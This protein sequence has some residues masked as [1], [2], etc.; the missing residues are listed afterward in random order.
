MIFTQ[1]NPP[2]SHAPIEDSP[3]RALGV[4]IEAYGRTVDEVLAR[5]GELTSQG[6]G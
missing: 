6:A 5:G 1:S 3:E 2:I 4:A